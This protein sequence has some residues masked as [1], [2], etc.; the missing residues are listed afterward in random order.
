MLFRPLLAVAG[1]ILLI[2]SV[3]A[4]A[5]FVAMMAVERIWPQREPVVIERPANIGITPNF[6]GNPRAVFICWS[7]EEEGATF[8]IRIRQWNMGDEREELR[9]GVEPL[10]CGGL[11]GWSHLFTVDNLYHF[12]LRACIGRDCSD[13]VPATPP[14]RYWLQIPCRDTAGQG[15]YYR[16]SDSTSRTP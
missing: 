2:G 10:D 14:E 6:L 5:F 8:D 3:G 4:G 1:A 13:W 12:D 11:Y 7:S 9:Q 16:G 15:C